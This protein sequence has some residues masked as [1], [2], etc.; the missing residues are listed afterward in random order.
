MTKLF[1]QLAA[2]V[3]EIAPFHVMELAKMATALEQQGRSIIHM[4]IGEPDYT[5]APAVVAA[6]TRAMQDGQ[7]QYTSATGLLA[8]RQE[9]SSHYAN[10]YGLS[11]APERIVITAGA[12]APEHLVEQLISYLK[13][14][15]FGTLEE[16]EIKEEDVRF[17][18]HLLML[19]LR[20]NC[21]HRAS[22][23]TRFR[24]ANRRSSGLSRRASWHRPWRAPAFEG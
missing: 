7:M 18:L 2:R 6:A 1:S 21:Y 15:G 13:D 12:S 4:G 11:I 16:L 3:D 9:I 10:V 19:E 22:S 5:A 14:G 24:A 8:L 20:T 17:S 23:P